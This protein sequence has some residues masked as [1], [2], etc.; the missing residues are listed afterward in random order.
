MSGHTY[1][2]NGATAISNQPKNH[3]EIVIKKIDDEYQVQWI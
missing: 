2:I 1:I 3:I